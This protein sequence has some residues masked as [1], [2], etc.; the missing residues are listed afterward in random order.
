MCPDWKCYSL[1][2]S[3]S[4]IPCLNTNKYLCFG[5]KKYVSNIKECNDNQRNTL[6]YGVSVSIYPGSDYS[7]PLI[8]AE[9]YEVLK[10]IIPS[11]FNLGN[12]AILDISPISQ[13]SINNIK[14]YVSS[15][16][17]NDY[18]SELSIY[19]TQLTG[20]FNIK[21]RSL[22]N[23]NNNFYNIPLVIKAFFPSYY[24]NNSLITA[25]DICLAYLNKDKWECTNY[26]VQTG[27]YEYSAR[28]SKDGTYCM[29]FSP[30][31]L[32]EEKEGFKWTALHTVLLIFV[33]VFLI[34]AYMIFIF[35]RRLS[36]ERKIEKRV[37]YYYIK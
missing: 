5:S 12:S 8:Y 24:Y 13:S 18:P 1:D 19:D 15:T 11:G 32:I 7:F 14:N 36:R 2:L 20:S 33:I 25:N 22:N 29:I 30:K 34:F 4:D 9:E 3:E 21:A 31:P 17:L 37:F 23:G 28:L 10:I 26:V 27:T 16:R 6:L 35:N